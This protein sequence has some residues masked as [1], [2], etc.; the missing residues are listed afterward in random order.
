MEQCEYEKS[1]IFAL[2]IVFILRSRSNCPLVTL[3]D[4]REKKGPHTHAFFSLLSPS[5]T[6]GD[7][8]E[9][10]GPHTHA[11]LC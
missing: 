5:V 3:G 7:S 1:K 11:F 10:K 4:S 6:R 8:R 9:K 2:K